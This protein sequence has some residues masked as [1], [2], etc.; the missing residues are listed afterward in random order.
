LKREAAGARPQTT[1]TQVEPT[2]GER[3]ELS[4]EIRDQ[5]NS[6]L[7]PEMLRWFELALRR[8]TQSE[9]E[10]MLRGYARFSADPGTVA[11]IQTELDRRRRRKRVR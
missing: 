9:L 7:E 4:D 2:A 10:G 6:V 1:V 11:A 8:T 5:P 3:P